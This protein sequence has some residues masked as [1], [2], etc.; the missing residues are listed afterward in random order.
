M[1]HPMNVDREEIDPVSDH[2]PAQAIT[3]HPDLP[4]TTAPRPSGRG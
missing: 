3:S 2:L 4:S 1:P